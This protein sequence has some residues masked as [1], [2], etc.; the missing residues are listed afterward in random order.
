M[1]YKLVDNTVLV[2]LD[3]GDEIHESIQKVAEHYN[4][5]AAQVSGIGAI[6]RITVG[7]YDPDS[8]EYHTIEYEECLEMTSM[9]GNISQNDGKHHGHFHITLSD[10]KGNVYGGHL[11]EA[12][13]RL[14]CEIFIRIL[15]TTVERQYDDFT[16]LMLWELSE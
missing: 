2:R 7:C 15:D 3:V 14:T 8:K 10:P 5:K 12:Y 6:E 1:E 9:Q 4:I 11:V 16:G 13:T